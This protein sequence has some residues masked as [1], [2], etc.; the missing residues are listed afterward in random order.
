VPGEEEMEWLSAKYPD[1]FDKHYR[2]PGALPQ[3]SRRPALLQQDAA[4]AVPD[5][6]DP[7]ALHRAGRP[8]RCLPRERL[9]GQKYHFCSDGCK[10][11]FD[12]EPEKYVQAWL[13]VHQIYQGNCFRRTWT[14]QARLRP[15]AA[16]LRLVQPEFG[17]DNLDYADSED[18]KNFEAWRAQATSN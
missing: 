1:T 5:L 14:R 8:T 7:D 9:Q 12:H 15:L 16:V 11:I 10:H 18:Q 13:P 3:S 6:P 4:H 17:R 2:P